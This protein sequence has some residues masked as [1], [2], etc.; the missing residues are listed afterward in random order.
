MISTGFR[1]ALVGTDAVDGTS[2]AAVDVGAR[3]GAA[4]PAM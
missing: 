3:G 2:G 1:A 4:Q